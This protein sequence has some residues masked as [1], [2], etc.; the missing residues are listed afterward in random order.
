MAHP[1]VFRFAVWFGKAFPGLKHWSRLPA[2]LAAIAFGCGIAI[3]NALP[4]QPTRPLYICTVCLATVFGAVGLLG[5][6]RLV[7]MAAFA[8][9]GVAVMAAARIDQAAVFDAVAKL[10][11]PFMVYCSGRIVSVPMRREGGYRFLVA[12]DSLY[13]RAGRSALHGKT[14]L[15]LTADSINL[16]GRVLARGSFF[17]PEHPAVPGAPDRYLYY[18]SSDI[19]GTFLAG[20]QLPLEYRPTFFERSADS[21]RQTVYAVLG[22]VGDE[23]R[24]ALLQAAFLGDKNPVPVRLQNIFRNAGITHLLAL[25]G[26]NVAMLAAAIAVLLFPLPIPRPWKLIVILAGL[27]WFLFVIGLIPSL[28][29]AVAMATLVTASL[30]FQRKSYPLN[31]LGLAA[32]IWLAMAPQSLFTPGFQLSFAATFAIVAIFPRLRTIIV[33]RRV[34]FKPALSFVLDAFWI[35]AACFIA[36]V[37]IIA[38]HFGSVSLYGLF[39]NI[40]AVSIMTFAL[41][42]VSAGIVFQP[43]IPLLAGLCAK[44]AGFFLEVLIRSADFGGRFAWSLV[45]VPLPTV[46]QII[47]FAL[48]IVGLFTVKRELAG[49]YTLV[50]LLAAAIVLPADGLASRAFDKMETCVFRG[51]ETAAMGL[52]IPRAG[53]YLFYGPDSAAVDS[54]QIRGWLRHVGAARCTRLLLGA[55][56]T[57]RDSADVVLHCGDTA[58]LAPQCRCVAGPVDGK[59]PALECTIGSNRVVFTGTTAVGSGVIVR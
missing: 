58:L 5:K 8:A 55:A 40:V 2:L 43:W 25:S 35:S 29:R 13:D 27:W 4:G 18:L 24:R 51:R 16:G 28:F 26:Q 9:A 3:G 44:T 47:V 42:A 14:I 33:L 50:A 23:G 20:H 32:V 6:R 59:R 19:W 56:S 31:A 11:R 49:R 48:F 38:W 57:A 41:W 7:R 22:N 36:T 45:Q 37:P 10:D 39:F 53:A 1:V 54:Q 46:G 12:C 34:R 15:F 30:L 21:F 17:V 52:Y